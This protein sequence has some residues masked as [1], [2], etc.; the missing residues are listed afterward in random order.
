[1]NILY[2]YGKPPNQ[3]KKFNSYTEQKIICHTIKI[4]GKVNIDLPEINNK[5]SNTIYFNDH[6][7]HGNEFGT[8]FKFSEKFDTFCWDFDNGHE[9]FYNWVEESA[10]QAGR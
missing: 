4:I 10:E 9:N 2:L 7:W 1:M 5:K 8:F 3:S 6:W